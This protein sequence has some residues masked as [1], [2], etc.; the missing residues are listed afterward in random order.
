[1]RI[2]V[3]IHVGEH[4]A[5]LTAIGDVE[6]LPVSRPKE[7]LHIIEPCLYHLRL[8]AVKRK[9]VDRPLGIFTYRELGSI[10]RNVK[11]KKLNIW[12][13][14]KSGKFRATTSEWIDG[15][16]NRMFA[17]FRSFA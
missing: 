4:S 10:R 12:V 7:W 6:T 2:T 13:Q 3:E 11:S 9:Y 16:K 15:R 17:I 8:P 5:A 14:I 1:M